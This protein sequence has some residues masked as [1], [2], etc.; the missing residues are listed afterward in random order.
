MRLLF[1]A[2]EARNALMVTLHDDDSFNYS[3]MT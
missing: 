1:N 3:T 2:T